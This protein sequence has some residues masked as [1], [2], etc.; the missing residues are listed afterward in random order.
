MSEKHYD[1][2][3][4][5]GPADGKRLIL[6]EAQQL[7]RV[8]ISNSHKFETFDYKLIHSS[9]ELLIYAAPHMDEGHVF[10]RLHWCYSP[11]CEK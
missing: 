7:F 1:A 3:F 4:V 10:R 9:F 5:G 2:L 8:P 11:K 6:P